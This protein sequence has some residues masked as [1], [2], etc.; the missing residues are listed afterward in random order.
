MDMVAVDWAGPRGVYATWD[1]SQVIQF[2]DLN[3]LLN[4]ISD[5]TMIV[6]EPA[7]ESYLPGRRDEFVLRC[8]SEGHLLLRISDR[9]TPR[10]RRKLGL[11]KSDANDAIAIWNLVRADKHLSPVHRVSEIDQD[12][13]DRVDRLN[14]EAVI[15]RFTGARAGLLAKMEA[16]LGPARDLPPDLRDVLADSTGRKYLAYCTAIY[17]AAEEARTRAEFERFLGLYQNA[18]ACMLRSEIVSTRNLWGC[19][20]RRGV[21]WRDYRRTLRKTYHLLRQGIK[22][23]AEGNG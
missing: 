21:S 13:I 7:F 18:W 16:V 11:E 19:A 12:W 23:P 14:R 22:R 10:M 4:Y 20:K 3:G 2:A 6:V 9:M 1:G 8:R 5:P 15:V 17:Q